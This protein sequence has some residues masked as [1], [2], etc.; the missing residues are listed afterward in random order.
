MTLVLPRSALR[1]CWN[2]STALCVLIL[3]L[4]LVASRKL[5]MCAKLP[6]DWQEM[7]GPAC[8]FHHLRKCYI[9]E[10]ASSL[11]RYISLWSFAR[12]LKLYVDICMLVPKDFWPKRSNRLT[13]LMATRT[14]GLRPTPR[15]SYNQWALRYN[16]DVF[17]I[18]FK[19]KP[20]QKK[21]YVNVLFRGGWSRFGQ[22]GPSMFLAGGTVLAR[23]I[24]E[25]Y[26]LCKS[27][28][29]FSQPRDLS[30]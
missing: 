28:F 21:C 20:V 1:Y 24:N 15:M 10:Y 12:T 26:Q 6:A 27:H 5:R 19:R 3:V 13:T 22:I 17:G 25:I 14:E 2:C 7:F 8:W 23:T 9:Y 29:L 4:E 11:L 18:H 16:S 30:T